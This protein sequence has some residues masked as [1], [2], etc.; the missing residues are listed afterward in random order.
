MPEET[1]TSYRTF[2]RNFYLFRFFNDFAFVYAVYIIL[3]KLNG[4]SVLEISLLLAL[5]CG[6]VVLFEVPTGALADR[7]NRKYML[8]LGM[9]S[10]AVG[11]G[12]W[13]F[14]DSFWLFACGFLFWGIQETFCSGTMEALLFDNLKDFKEEEAYEK[15]AGRGHFYSRIAIATSTF[16]GGFLASISFDLVIVLS[17]ISMIFAFVPTLFFR[18][19]RFSNQLTDRVKYIQVLKRAYQESLRNKTI[20]R[21]LLYTAAVL[22]VFGTLDE[23]EQLYFNWVNLPI[24]FFG[25]L[26]VLR[27]SLEAIGCRI[28]HRFQGY[29]KNTN[30][31]Y[32]LAIFSGIFLASSVAH[33]SLYMLPVFALV[34]LFGSMGEVL[35]EG[36]LQ[37]NIASDQRATVLSINSF[38]LNASAIVLVVGFGILSE[39]GQLTWGFLAFASLVILFSMISMIFKTNE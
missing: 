13:L 33:Q 18:E 30:N 21:L 23:Y 10:K 39:I 14:A 12:I 27:M 1:N 4:R 24:A 3:F 25:V 26:M 34:F 7:W 17:C 31:I 19:I 2:I 5:W 38:L 16:L 8:S 36:R 15:V 28:A 11:F 9:F 22:A 29:N 35:V 37:R 6:F 32:I 20:F